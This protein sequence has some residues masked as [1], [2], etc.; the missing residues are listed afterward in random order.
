MKGGP[1]PMTAAAGEGEEGAQGTEGEG[2]PALRAGGRPDLVLLPGGRQGSRQGGP[3]PAEAT[4][5]VLRTW[6]SE[7]GSR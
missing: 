6:L 4:A 3:E 7:S 2:A 5:E 1:Q